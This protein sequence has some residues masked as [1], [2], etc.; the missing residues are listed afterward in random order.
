MPELSPSTR[1]LPGSNQLLAVATAMAEVNQKVEQDEVLAL[2]VD[3]A[4]ACR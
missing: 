4:A 2:G 1:A 3:R